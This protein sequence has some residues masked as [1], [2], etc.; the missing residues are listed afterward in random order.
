MKNILLVVL[1]IFFISCKD[2]DADLTNIFSKEDI[3][4]SIV[5]FDFDIV[6]GSNLKVEFISSK[7]INI[8]SKEYKNKFL[9][10]DFWATWCPSCVNEMPILK[11]IAKKYKK[12]LNFVGIN[13]EVDKSHNDITNFVK[14]NNINYF[15]S[16]ND[17]DLGSDLM[18][19][20]T[21]VRVLPYKILFDKNGNYVKHYYGAVPRELIETDIDNLIKSTK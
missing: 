2:K 13:I 1:I 4:S 5:Y 7:K 12:S 18:N 10:L 20:L 15:I 6:N 9:L 14:S 8:I 11:D 17:K 21:N 19:I 16:S 3:Q